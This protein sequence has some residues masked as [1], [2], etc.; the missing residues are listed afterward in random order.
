MQ[1]LIILLMVVTLALTAACANPTPTPIPPSPTP[2]PLS[3]YSDLPVRTVDEEYLVRTLD[4][5]ILQGC[6]AGP[7]GFPVSNGPGSYVVTFDG[8]FRQ[9]FPRA[10]VSGID[11]ALPSIVSGRGCYNMAVQFE[12]EMRISRGPLPPIG[13][14]QGALTPAY[15]LIKPTAFERVAESN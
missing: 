12:E 11:F 15:R 9:A 10:V 7:I 3:G 5:F 2:S 14:G 13:D 1:R 4:P 8:H 6:I